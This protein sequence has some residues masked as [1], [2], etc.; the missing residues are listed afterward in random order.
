[1]VRLVRLSFTA[2]VDL[3]FLIFVILTLETDS[4]STRCCRCR[5][6]LSSRCRR[7]L[8]SRGQPRGS[9]GCRRNRSRCCRSRYSGLDRHHIR[10]LTPCV[11]DVAFDLSAG[12]VEGEPVERLAGVGD[13]ENPARATNRCEFRSIDPLTDRRL[14]RALG[15]QDFGPILMTSGVARYVT[16]DQRVER[17]VAHEDGSELGGDQGRDDNVLRGGAG[18]RTRRSRATGD[19]REP[20]R[21]ET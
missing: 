18:R 16:G 11:G 13:L 15:K 8:S 1:V 3:E 4:P 6:G 10:P 14:G 17:R 7:G 9:S 21:G 19:Q 2:S 20:A 5:R 12:V